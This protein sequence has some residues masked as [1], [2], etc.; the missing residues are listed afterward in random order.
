MYG[1]TGRGQG[2]IDGMSSFGVKNVLR[3]DIVTYDI[4]FNKSE[5]IVDYLTIK[6]P[7]FK[8]KHFPSEEI[9]KSLVAQND[10]MVI[11]DCMK[12]HLLI[13]T[14]NEP[15]FCKESLCSCNCC[16]QFNFKECLEEMF[17]CMLMYLAM[18]SMVMI[19]EM[20]ASE[21]IF[22][23]L[24]VPSFVTLFSGN[25]TEPLYF[26]KVTEKGTGHEDR[27]DSYV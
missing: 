3:K 16:L 25:Q 9:V 11:T 21:Q 12:Q 17:L 13:F 8:Y 26:V 27:T 6:C 14:P 4:F 15:V 24:H 1:A 22:D 23:F 2:A 5:D 19:N 20:M 18:T 7:Q 10:S